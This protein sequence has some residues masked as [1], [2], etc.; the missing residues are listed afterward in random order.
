MERD[1]LDFIPTGAAIKRGLIL[2]LSCLFASPT[3]GA[4]NYPITKWSMQDYHKG[5][6][7]RLSWKTANGY[8][9]SIMKWSKEY[10][11]D[12]DWM[13]ALFTVESHWNTNATDGKDSWGI[14]QLQ[15]DTAQQT[16]D[17]LK[18]QIVVTPER[19]MGD[20]DLAIRLACRH[21]RDLLDL[22]HGNCIEATRAYNRGDQ[23]IEATRLPGLDY[24]QNVFTQY[25]H[26]EVFKTIDDAPLTQGNN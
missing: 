17:G 23:R 20:P 25:W 2:F 4:L 13:V 6:H 18:L 12:P 7:K 26:F 24:F 3:F 1:E 11:I 10:D 5:C 9:Q 8:A 14:P 16:A 21:Y 19:L 15:V 22:F